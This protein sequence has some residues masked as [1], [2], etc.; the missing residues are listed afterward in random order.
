MGSLR[1]LSGERA[2]GHEPVVRSRRESAFVDYRI[3]RKGSV[4]ELSC[5]ERDLLDLDI[6]PDVSLGQDRPHS[7]FHRLRDG[8]SVQPTSASWIAFD[9]L[10]VV[11]EI[12]R[13][14]TRNEPLN[15]TRA[16]RPDFT[17]EFVAGIRSADST[18]S[19]VIWVDRSDAL[20]T[21][22]STCSGGR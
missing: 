3:D 21:A 20:S 15:F 19:S 2:N 17:R 16:C 22:P 6:A 4:S 18:S 7:D 12:A 13:A 10:R 8:V 5:L 11:V 9:E 14:G 1:S